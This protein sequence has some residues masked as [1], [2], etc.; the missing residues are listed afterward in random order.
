MKRGKTYF[1][2]ERLKEFV[3]NRDYGFLLYIV[4]SLRI[5]FYGVDEDDCKGEKLF[6]K[7]ERGSLFAVYNNREMHPYASDILAIPNGQ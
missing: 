2:R 4:D 5:I 7:K 1:L 6:F 3:K